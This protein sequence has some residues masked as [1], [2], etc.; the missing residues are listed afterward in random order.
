MQTVVCMRWGD[1]Y[2]VDYVN[3]L[4]SMIRRHT[5]RPTRLVCYTDSPLGADPAIEC[6]PLPPI[7][8]P[9]RLRFLPW[10]KISLW[11]PTLEG[12]SGEALYLDLDIVIT[13]PLD[14]FFDYEQGKFCVIRNWTRSQ[15]GTGNTTAY[16]FTVGSAV[17]L[18][19][20]MEREP[21]AVYREFGNSQTFVTRAIGLPTAYWP[22][23][24]CV[25]FKHSL[26]PPWPLNFLRAPRLPEDA[27]IV[28]FTGHPDPDEALEGR[29]PA[30]GLKKLY[31]HVRPTPWIAEHWR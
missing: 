24:W 27:R 3:R 15:G 17:H 23:R 31:K 6:Y 28:A 1:R 2:G 20:R 9:E 7:E 14:D 29:W 11:R 26:L 21:M 12:V 10:R 25:S 19:E 16:R 13:G 4:W 30:A 8:L 22:E 5:R 18:F